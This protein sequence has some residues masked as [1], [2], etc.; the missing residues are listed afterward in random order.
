M[1]FRSEYPEF[2]KAIKDYKVNLNDNEIKV[3]FGLFDRDGSGFVDY[4]EFL[5]QIRGEMNDARKKV[6]LQAFDKLDID[7]SG[8]IELNDVKSLYNAKKN[9]EVLS[10]K[11][12]EEDVYGEF[13]ETF[14]THHNIKKGIRDR[15]V[16]REEFIE[17]YNNISMSVEDD[18]YF[19]E[20]GRAHV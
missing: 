20:I 12:T 6:V 8:I 13:I 3:L 9:K 5:R 14:E 4:D 17:Y 16:T 1:L 11:K 19:I 2:V 7:K 15:R 10:G 18:Q